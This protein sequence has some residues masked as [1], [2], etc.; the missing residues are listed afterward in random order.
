MLNKIDERIANIDEKP[1][2]AK[3]KNIVSFHQVSATNGQNIDLLKTKIGEEIDS[4]PLIGDKL[5]KVWFEIRTILESLQSN[6]IS[7]EEYLN[8]CNQQG[9]SNKRALFLS[10]Y[11]YNLGVFLHFQDDN[12]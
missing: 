10:Q 12:L 9:L 3:F 4:L 11:F 1:L 6:C 7:A 2:K 5:P 8:I